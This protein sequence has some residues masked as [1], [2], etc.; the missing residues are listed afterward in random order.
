MNSIIDYAKEN[1][2]TDGKNLIINKSLESEYKEDRTIKIL[3]KEF[4]DFILRIFSKIGSA[5]FHPQ[6]IQAIIH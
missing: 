5:V 2:I 4:S 3:T 6:L 1:K